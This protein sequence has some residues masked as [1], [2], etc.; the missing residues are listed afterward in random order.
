MSL[1]EVAVLTIVSGQPT[2]QRQLANHHASLI[3]GKISPHP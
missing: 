1:D 3:D 2:P